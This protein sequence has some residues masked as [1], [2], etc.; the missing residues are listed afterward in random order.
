MNDTEIQVFPRV[1]TQ[2]DE[3]QA[4]AVVTQ[5]FQDDPL[6]CYLI[7]SI[8]HRASLKRQFFRIFLRI[9][10][11]NHSPDLLQEAVDAFDALHTPGFD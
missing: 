5:A 1:L 2:A 6:W 9:S 7:P 4:I 11:N 10:I 8:H 3:D